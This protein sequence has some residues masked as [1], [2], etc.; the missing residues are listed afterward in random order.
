MIIKKFLHSCTLIE[1]NGKRLL[2]DPGDFVF[3]EGK[4]SP[5]DLGGVDVI[6]FT[7]GH[8]DHFSPEAL[9]IILK[10]KPAVVLAHEEIAKVLTQEG[11]SYD[12]IS[13]GE[14]KIVQG[15]QIEAFG[16][17]HGPSTTVPAPFN[18]A[19]KIDNKVL[20]PGDC[21]TLEG[22]TA[23]VLALPVVGSWMRV[24][25]AIEFA[26]R[27]KPQKV[28]PIHDVFIKESFI[29]L[30]YE[31]YEK[32]LAEASIDFIRTELGKEIEI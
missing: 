20:H 16:A 21:I 15:F 22:V 24:V 9:K 6:L 31:S 29:E 30:F 13:A 18:M 19:Y 8:A 2:I 17:P 32:R 26:K 28:I 12:T 3:R 5:K 4:I 23:P 11:I 25:D 10:S 27:V 1:E 7:H 14:K